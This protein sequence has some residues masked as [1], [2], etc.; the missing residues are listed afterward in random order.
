[1]NKVKLKLSALYGKFGDWLAGV[2]VMTGEADD[3]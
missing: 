3:D 2:K 1:M